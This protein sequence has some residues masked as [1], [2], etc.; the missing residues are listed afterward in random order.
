[1]F[2]NNIN[3][4]FFKRSIDP[5]IFSMNG[6]NTLNKKFKILLIKGFTVLR[7]IKGVFFNVNRLCGVKYLFKDHFQIRVNKQLILRRTML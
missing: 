2:V 1:M 7:K 4:S 3:I 6:Q 5:R